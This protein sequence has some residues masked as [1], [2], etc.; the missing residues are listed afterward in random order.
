MLLYF[1]LITFKPVSFS[2][3]EEE[4]NNNNNNN[5]NNNDEINSL[6]MFTIEIKLSNHCFKREINTD[7]KEAQKL[8]N[9]QQ[10]S[11]NFKVHVILPVLLSFFLVST[12][13]VIA[14]FIRR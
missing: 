11:T 3:Y 2:N 1:E 12:L 13:I 5:N 7:L 14:L 4:D 10:N 9:Y 6:D 8:E